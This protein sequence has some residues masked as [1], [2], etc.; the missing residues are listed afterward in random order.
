M[1]PARGGRIRGPPPWPPAHPLRVLLGRIGVLQRER[2]RPAGGHGRRTRALELA[3]KVVRRRQEGPSAAGGDL[4]GA[5]GL[6]RVP[7]VV[8]R[9]AGERQADDR[10]ALADDFAIEVV[11]G[12][13]GVA[14]AVLGGLDPRRYGRAQDDGVALPELRADHLVEVP[15]LRLVDVALER[16]T[17]TA[18]CVSSLGDS[19]RI[20]RFC[21]VNPRCSGASE[22]GTSGRAGTSSHSRSH[23][24]ISAQLIAPPVI[25]RAR[26]A[27]APQAG[28]RS[29]IGAGAGLR[30]SV[31]LAG[32][33][34][35]RGVQAC[36]RDAGH[37]RHARETS[38]VGALRE[39]KAPTRS[40]A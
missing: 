16:N 33:P 9:I 1:L 14:V 31:V 32:F 22:A 21:C 38:T 3:G 15:E 27:S 18:V 6:L 19:Q 8:V 23:V 13:E 17:R 24:V 28:V 4:L 5:G 20:M 40:P 7:G 2:D 39:G 37:E 10:V 35:G 12:G 36:G 30:C 29:P 25:D 11:Q 34:L 26:R